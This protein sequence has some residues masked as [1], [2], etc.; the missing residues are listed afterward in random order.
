VI[1]RSVRGYDRAEVDRLLADIADSFE[2]VWHE[3][4]RL[5]Q[6]VLR[7]QEQLRREQAAITTVRSE[8]ERAR[9]DRSAL[10]AEL[11]QAQA[12]VRQLRAAM[13]QLEPG[14]LEAE[15]R[16]AA[17]RA[18]LREA[19]DELRKERDRLLDE[20]RR[21]DAATAEE[22]NMRERLVDFLLDGL[23][24]VER[25]PLNGSEATV[26]RGELPF[27]D[28]AGPRSSSDSAPEDE[29]TGLPR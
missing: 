27:Q 16:L 11:E 1:S 2:A 23:K 12:D 6:D 26:E 7:L 14:D 17:E 28:G 3:R 24:R 21:M 9:A 20:V 10:L 22:R 4:T 18:Q 8:V 19:T 15:R 13:E 5:Y 25:V 29:S